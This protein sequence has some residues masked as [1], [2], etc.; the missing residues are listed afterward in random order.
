MRKMGALFGVCAATAMLARA[1]KQPER[2]APPSTIASGTSATLTVAAASPTSTIDAPDGSAY[3]APPP[4]TRNLAGPALS[5]FPTGTIPRW[6]S[7]STTGRLIWLVH[8]PTELQQQV[9]H[10]QGWVPEQKVDLVIE[11]EN[12]SVRVRLLPSGGALFPYNQGACQ[13]KS[14]QHAY[15]KTD[16]QLAKL[17]FYEGG[18]LGYVVEREGQ[19]LRINSWVQPSGL[20]VE[21]QS[22]PKACP[23]RVKLVKAVPVPLSV[24]FEEQILLVKTDGSTS[25]LSCAE[26]P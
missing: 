15:D 18:A 12:V 9:A 20:C 21:K 11:V 1:C 19:E 5:A 26:N 22:K 10:D 7:T 3:A 17:I 25:I 14:P 2:V 8:E 13:G 6:P 24:R 16:S 23:I 4:S